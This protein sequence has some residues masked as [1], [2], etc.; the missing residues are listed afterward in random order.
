MLLLDKVVVRNKVVSGWSGH[1]VGALVS[2]HVVKVVHLTLLVLLEKTLVSAHLLGV[3]V[4]KTLG[5]AVKKLRRD[6]VQNVLSVSFCK[7]ISISTLALC[8]CKE[9]NQ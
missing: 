5:D 8:N 9:S 2:P 1:A 7:Q 6:H 3:L 4:V